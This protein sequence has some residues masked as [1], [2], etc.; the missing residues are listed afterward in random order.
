MKDKETTSGIGRRDFLKTVGAT[1]IGLGVA[2]LPVCPRIVRPARAEPGSYD[3]CR[4]V[5][6]GADGLR[7]DYAQT[8]R[9][10]GAPGLSSLNPPICAICGGMSQTQPGWASIWSGLPSELNL[11]WDNSK[12]QRMPSGYH[13]ME[14]LIKAYEGRDLYAVWI[15]GKGNIVGLRQRAN[16]KFRKG[17]HYGVY[18]MI[19]EEGNPGVY[20]GDDSRDNDTVHSLAS[21]ALAEAVQHNNFIA[22]VQ[23]HDPDKTGHAS[24]RSRLP[25][26]YETYMQKALEIDN[27]IANLM[28][29][30]PGD[31]DIIY[32]SD[33]GF[34]FVSQ[35]D[36]RNHHPFSPK[37][38][39]ATNVSTVD[40]PF[41][42]Q[43]SIGRMIYRLAGGNPDQTQR[44]NKY[45]R[46]W[47]DDLIL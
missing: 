10:Q 29:L 4:I 35:G 18:K 40:T 32:C 13:I 7:I 39:L 38:T 23:F 37:A 24:V 46:M 47:G 2:A 16:G 25:N 31:T 41:T 42:S 11:A 6:F 5:V 33:H 15:V 28:G 36:A 45:Y 30:L 27:Y 21:Q 22:F 26:D 9:D 19:V 44:L 8:L 1:A 34:D 17:S 3:N 20:Y 12:Y 43:M 14:K